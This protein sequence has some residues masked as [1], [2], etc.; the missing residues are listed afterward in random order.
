MKPPD[1]PQPAV[2]EPLSGTLALAGGLLVAGDFLMWGHG[3]GL[4]LAIFAVLIGAVLLAKGSRTKRAWI[5]FALLAASCV[6][7][8]IGLCLTNVCMMLL[9]IAILLGE[10][11][12][13]TL[14]AGCA[15]W[16][17]GFLAW[18][19]G[20]GRWIWLIEQLFDSTRWQ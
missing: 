7:A 8:A 15:R 6:Q 11:R 16:L 19:K 5:A 18:L 13:D 12:Y 10:S 3:P 20:L 17:E 1:L 2:L 9:M 14:P 4:G